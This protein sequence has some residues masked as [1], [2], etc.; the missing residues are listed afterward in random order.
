[1]LVPLVNSTKGL[2]RGISQ[3]TEDAACQG[4]SE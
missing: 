1:M 3:R 2:Q 4:K